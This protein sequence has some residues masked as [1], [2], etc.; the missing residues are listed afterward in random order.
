MTTIKDLPVLPSCSPTDHV[1]EA[2]LIDRNKII[3]PEDLLNHTNKWK[4][5][6]DLDFKNRG[7]LTKEEKEL[8]DGS[9]D[10]EETFKCFSIMQDERGHCGHGKDGPCHAMHIMVPRPLITATFI[11]YQY[12]VNTDIT[13]LQMTGGVHQVMDD[14]I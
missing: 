4:S 12:K 2:Y 6:W 10:V 7:E 8:I 5:L 1:Q 14:G 9:Y 13:L 11:S 3:S